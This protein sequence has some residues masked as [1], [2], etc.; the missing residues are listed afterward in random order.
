MSPPRF[1][2]PGWSVALV[3]AALAAGCGGS[4]INLFPDVT[5][6]EDARDDAATPP[7]ATFDGGGR[8]ASNADCRADQFCAGTGCGTP[9]VCQTRPDA[10]AELYSP[11]CGCDGRTYGNACS[12]ASVGVRVASRGVCAA[13]D[14]GVRA[15]VRS[16]ECGTRENCVYPDTACA[17]AGTCQ[18]TIM[19]FRAE[20]FCACTGETFWGCVPDRPTRSRGECPSAPDAGVSRCAAVLC[21]PGTTCCE[22]TGACYDT[23]CL[24][25]CPTTPPPPPVDAGVPGCGSNS[26][27]GTR[28]YCA[29]SACGARGTCT[30]RPQACITLYDPVCGCDGRTYGNACAAASAGMNV[31]YRGACR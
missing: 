3:A 20:P 19:C 8:C 14:A 25:C 18:P 4:T 31:S 17:R 22:A 16:S 15:C 30:V 28:E 1:K 23:R 24:G 12:A 5:P 21:G 10:C 13:V 29:A 9:G 27:C 26:D 2:P 7:D 6:S 11:V